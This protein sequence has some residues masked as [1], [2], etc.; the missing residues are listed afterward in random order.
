MSAGSCRLEVAVDHP[1]FSGHFPGHPIVPGVVLIEHAA[2]ALAAAF[3]L[4]TPCWQLGSAKFV[5][6]V[7]PGELLRLSWRA[8]SASGAIAFAIDSAGH[9]VASGT[10]TPRPPAP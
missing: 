7:G 10:L 9:A 1:A 3:D 4:G 5:R 2:R 8:P 6:P